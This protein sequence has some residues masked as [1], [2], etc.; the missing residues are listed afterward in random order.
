MAVITR[1]G[2]QVEEHENPNS[3]DYPTVKF[4]LGYEQFQD[5]SKRHVL[6]VRI[7]GHLQELEFGKEHE[8]P[9]PYV[10]V[11]EDARIRYVKE[12]PLGKYEHA[13]GGQ[14]RPQSEI[15]QAPTIMADIPMYDVVRR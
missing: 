2:K 4:Y 12:S 11:I 7:N 10:K 8:V 3:G 9:E 13:V 14:G 6:R 1:K 15:F 5:R